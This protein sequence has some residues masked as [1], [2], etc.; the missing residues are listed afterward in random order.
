MANLV[1]LMTFVAFE[2]HVSKFS[3]RHHDMKTLSAL[4]VGH[5]SGEATSHHLIPCTKAIGDFIIRLIK[6]FNKQL[7]S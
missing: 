6:P 1:F 7:S 2:T 5:S 4:L 3:W